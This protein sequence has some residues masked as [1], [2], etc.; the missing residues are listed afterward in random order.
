MRRLLDILSDRGTVVLVLIFLA[1]LPAV[2]P[3]IYATDEIEYFSYL[4]S[5]WFDHDLN[6][7]N[8]YLQFYSSDPVKYAQFKRDLLDK[9]MPNT[10]LP[11][12]VAPIGSAVLW[13]PFYGAADILVRV[14]NL[15]GMHIPADGYSAPYVYAVCYASTL[16]GF[17]GLLLAYRTV[18][19]WVSPVPALLATLA[20]WWGSPLAFYMYVTPPMS[21][22]NSFFAVTLFLVAW[23]N[24]RGSTSFWRW[25]G[26]GGLAGLMA[27]V[28]EQDI[29][30]SLVLVV[31]LAALC[32]PLIRGGKVRDALHWLGLASTAA[33]AA[34]LA[35]APQLATYLV[36][37]GRIGPS[38]IVA[39]KLQWTSPHFFQVLFSPSHGLLFWS[40]GWLGVPFGLYLLFKKDRTLAF[41]LTLGFLSQVYIAG[42]FQTW[43]AAGSFG[44]RRFV[45]ASFILLACL[46]AVT[47]KLI[48]RKRKL[49]AYGL[50]GLLA[51]YNLS[52]VVQWSALW[53]TAQRQGL[54][55]RVFLSYEFDVLPK[56][57]GEIIYR[58]LFY[59][60]SFFQR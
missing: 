14:L 18:R 60:S 34:L 23:L 5:L 11:I 12:N 44:A 19:R 37:G 30:Y 49:P 33:V 32:I 48:V 50:V 59:R 20:V 56:R 21:H 43:S 54:D 36:L 4:R 7:E 16:Y 13:A 24:T 38:P 26:L 40:P 53:T 41:A 10:G 28:R 39:D 45:G 15:L 1:S 2:T 42:A 31:E 25:L 46:A 55:W 58:F 3:R 57:I 6:F 27:M 35:F 22:A 47:G 8:E 52:L 9:R 51:L 29:L 17:L